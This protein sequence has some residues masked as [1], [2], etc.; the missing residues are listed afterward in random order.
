MLPTYEKSCDGMEAYFQSIKHYA[1]LTKEEELA[2]GRR[3][4]ENPD[5]IEAKTQLIER[6][7]GLPIHIAKKFVGHGLS[8]ADL[9]QE[10]N[11]GLMRAARLYNPNKNSRFITYAYPV[12]HC[13][14]YRAL[15]EKSRFIRLPSK[16][17][18]ISMKL[19]HGSAVSNRVIKDKL[20]FLKMNSVK[21]LANISKCHVRSIFTKDSNGIELISR[22]A[23]PNSLKLFDRIDTMD[24]REKLKP[25]IDGVIKILKPD[26]RN[27]IELLYGLNG[28]KPHTFREV[29]QVF[30]STFQNIFLR[31]RHII[32]KLQRHRNRLKDYV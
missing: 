15:S 1:D 29:G 17:R 18:K 23:D 28:N 10:G 27:I 2:L 9:V 25:V 4:R 22:I 6:S 14:I 11:I 24:S 5:D 16:L 12:I 20:K 21:D 8:F 7:L 19:R 3:I 30:G 26:D 13:R 31:H 32:L